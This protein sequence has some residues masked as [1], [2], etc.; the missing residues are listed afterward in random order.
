MLW[1]PWPVRYFKRAT[2]PVL[3]AANRILDERNLRCPIILLPASSDSNNG[4]QGGSSGMW[5]Y[6]LRS[7]C[8]FPIRVILWMAPGRKIMLRYGIQSITLERFLKVWTGTSQEMQGLCAHHHFWD[9]MDIKCQWLK[10][11]PNQLRPAAHHR[12]WHSNGFPFLDVPLELREIIIK[13]AIGPVAIPYEKYIRLLR[14]SS[15]NR[16]ILWLAL[17]NRQ[18]HQEVMQVLLKQTP[19]QF[20]NYINFHRFSFTHRSTLSEIRTIRLGGLKPH[21]L[22]ALVGVNLEC[23]NGIYMYSLDLTTDTTSPLIHEELKALR[24]I[25]IHIPFVTEGVYYLARNACQKAFCLAFWVGARAFLR[26][27]DVVELVG[28][29]SDSQKQDFVNELKAERAHA[30]MSSEK[31]R[32]WQRLTLDEWYEQIP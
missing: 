25:R 4:V 1:D 7:L 3:N 22:L 29:I 9:S 31:F 27:V 26:H 12:W 20:T 16:R 24:H 32:H 2:D 8:M 11:V 15:L 23:K 10:E 21:E 6:S 14:R 30:I 17:V 13:F 19:F 5:V 18:F 28:C